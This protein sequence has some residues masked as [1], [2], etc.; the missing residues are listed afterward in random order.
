MSLS[1]LIIRA[2]GLLG[3]AFTERAD[4]IRINPDIGQELIKINLENVLELKKR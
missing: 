4:I 3:D 2:G 1:Q